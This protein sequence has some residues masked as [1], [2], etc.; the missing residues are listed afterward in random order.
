M[1][2]KACNLCNSTT[3][4]IFSSLIL[5]KYEV[6]YYRCSSCE[7]IHTEP[8]YWIEEAYSSSIALTDTGIIL[9]N[10]VNKQRIIIALTLLN[11]LSFTFSKFKPYNF[12]V[13]DYGAG[14]G[15][16]V[17][18]LRDIG[19]NAYWYDKY[20]QNL[21]ARGFEHNEDI[22]I[23]CLLAFELFEHLEYPLE[24]LTKIINSFKPDTIIFSTLLYEGSC[25]NK[26]WWYY[27][28]ETGQHISFYNQTTLNKLAEILDYNYYS[29]LPDFHVFSKTPFDTLKIQKYF[30]NIEGHFVKFSNLYYSKTFNDHLLMKELLKNKFN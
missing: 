12:N 26:D 7:L 6:K 29:I 16:L 30:K 13:L 18:M 15:I 9:R 28:F 23:N 8:V 22:R 19:I 20:T 2:S 25:P 14:Y 24:E 21:F 27:S 3:N 1:N 5:N 10:E 11:N 4:L 17:R